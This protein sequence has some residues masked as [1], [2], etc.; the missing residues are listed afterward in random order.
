M[1]ALDTP[2]RKI[3]QDPWGFVLGVLK[4][5]QANQGLLL[6]G[7]LAY[8]MLLS[9]IPLLTLLLVVLSH[10][11]DEAALMSTLGRYIGLVIPG[12]S[13]AIIKQMKNFLQHREIAGWVVLGTM[14]F[15]STLAFSVLENAM[16][17]I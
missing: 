14:L 7:A 2:L 5:F 10:V 11:V 9:I 17:I 4:A 1:S 13:D 6:A 12:E 16:S 3:T 8:Y 15:F